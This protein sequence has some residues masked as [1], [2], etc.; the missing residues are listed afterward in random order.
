MAKRTLE[1]AGFGPLIGAG[2]SATRDQFTPPSLVDA[3]SPHVLVEQ[4]L[5]PPR[6]KPCVDETKVTDA[7]SKPASAS[8]GGPDGGAAGAVVG[9]GT[10]DGAEVGPLAE[11]T[12]DVAGAADEETAGALD[13]TAVLAGALL[14]AEVACVLLEQ[15]AAAIRATSVMPPARVV[16]EV[17]MGSRTQEEHVRVHV[18]HRSFRRRQSSWTLSR[19]VARR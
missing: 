8:A 5:E 18:S 12:A 10:D 6:T 9:A 2:K 7:G 3:S 11:A 16:H 1:T 13:A 15:P 17:V 19:A 14:L 4:V